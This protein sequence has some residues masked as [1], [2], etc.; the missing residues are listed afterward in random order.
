MMN[1]EKHLSPEGFL[2]I[3]EL[4]YFANHTTQ[5]TLETKQVI[6]DKIKNKLNLNKTKQVI[7]DKIKNKLNLNT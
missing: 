4:C 5:R 7:L 6:L 1:N 3:L 2:Q